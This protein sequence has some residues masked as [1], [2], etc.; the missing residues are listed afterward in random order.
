MNSRFLGFKCKWNKELG[1]YRLKRVE[2]NEVVQ[3]SRRIK[4]A[5]RNIYILL[6]SD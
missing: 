5:K 4:G 6:H 1:V 2:T 3:Q